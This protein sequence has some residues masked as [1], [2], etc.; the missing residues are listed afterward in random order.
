MPKSYPDFPHHTHIA[1][2]FDDYVD[3][4]GF[5][6][7][8]T[9][10]DRRRARRARRRRRL[11]GHARRRRDARATTRWWSPTA[12]TGTRAGPSRR[13]RARDDFEGVQMHSH[14][15]TATTRAA[16]ATSAW[17][18]SG[19]AT[20]RWTSRSRRASSPSARLPG[21]P[22]RRVDHPQV[23]VRPAARPD[24][25]H[26]AASRCAVR[27]RV[28]AAAAARSRVGDMERYGLPKP[29]HRF[30]ARRT[31]RSP[32]T[33]SSASPTA[34]ITPKPN[35]ARLDRARR[36]A[37]RRRQRG[38]GRRRRLLHRLQGHV[39]VLRRGLHLRA[40][41]RPAAVPA[42]LPPATSTT[43]FFIGLLQPL[44]AIMPLA[45]AQSEWI[46][47]LPRGPLRAAAAPAE[48]RADIERERAAMFKRYVASKRHTMQVDY[49]D[50]LATWRRSAGAAPS[51]RARGLRAAGAAA[52]RAAGAR[53]D[54]PSPAARADEGR[55]PRRDPRRRARG[56]RRARLR[57]GRRARHRP[58]HR[59]RLGHVL[60]L[61]PRQGGGL[62]R[63]RARRPAPEARRRVRAAR[64]GAHDAD[65]LR[66]R[67]RYRAYFAFIVEDPERVRVPAPQRRHDPR[68]VRRR[69]R[70]RAGIDE[71]AEDLRAAIAAGQLPALD[72]DYCAHAMVA[73]GL[74][75]G[76]RLA[77]RDAARRRGRDARSRPRCSS[78]RSSDD[79][80][81]H[82][83]GPGGCSRRSPRI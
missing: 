78:G 50:Y 52:R 39:P 80:P 5:R 54:A 47:R 73:V 61:L 11:G 23:P 21:R 28:H 34:T 15:Y 76:A 4:F 66:R 12:T 2:Y 33:S 44:G 83:G 63:A 32:T 31:R 30:A 72:V 1:A 65:E 75:L 37:L 74:E 6:D 7:R 79:R 14:D 24:R 82:R 71:L 20:R 27:Q 56:L 68:A 48:L 26:A 43:S 8:I 64:R 13:S 10:R 18:C 55:E 3:H 36:V 19:W 38:R 49:D 53:R 42:R 16:S 9:L 70:C 40:R 57:R 25:G 41:Q 22:P 29:D 67:T 17:S 62:P 46:V 58:P 77:E 45:E 69:R 81:G 59:P 35:I 60:Q 51:G